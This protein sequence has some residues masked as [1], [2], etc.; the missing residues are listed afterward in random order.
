MFLYKNI[1][2]KIAKITLLAMSLIISESIVI[3][4]LVIVKHKCIEDYN[5]ST[6]TDCIGVLCI[7]YIS[8]KI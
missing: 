3:T 4:V 5:V 6:N 2:K 8:H 1:H 7:I